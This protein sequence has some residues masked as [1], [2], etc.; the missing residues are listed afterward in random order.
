MKHFGILLTGLFLCLALSARADETRPPNFIVVFVDD[1]GYADIG[2]FGSPDIRTPRLDGLAQ[3]GMRFTH[4]YAQHICG[5]SRTALMTGSHPQRVAEK[6]NIKRIHPVVHS[7]E[8]T[9]AE[10]L[11]TRGYATGC[12]GKWD[13]AG[14]SQT[15]FDPGLM[16][17]HQGFD[18][19]FGTPSSND[20][21]VD[22]YRNDEKIEAKADMG[23]L[24]KRN[25]DEVI[26]FIERNR[27]QPFFAYVPYSMV[28]TKLGAS[29]EFKD[30]SPRGLYGDAVEE[31]DFNCGRI[32]DA[33]KEYDLAKNT[34][35]LFTSDNGPWLIKNKDFEDGKLTTDHG[36]SAGPLRSGKVSTWEGGVRVP[37]ILW[38]P[39]HVPANTECN[40]IAA[41]ID[42]LPTFAKLAGTDAPTDRVL[43]GIDIRHLFEGKFDLA[44]EERTFYYYFINSLQAVRQGKWKL[45]LP[46]PANPKWLGKFANNKHIAKRDWQGFKTAFLIDLET[47]PGET[48]DVAADHPKVVERLLGIAEEAREDIGDHDRV[49]KNVR[50]F[51]PIKDQPVAKLPGGLILDLD[52][53]HGVTTEDGD[54]VSL[55]ENQVEESLA[56]DFIKRDKGRKKPGTGRPTL[57]NALPGLKGHNALSFLQQELVC[58][59]E[60]AFDHLTQGSGCT[61]MT[62]ISVREQRVGLKDVNSF[63]GNLKNGKFYGGLWGCLNDDNTLWWGMRNGLSFGRFDE[64]NPKLTGPKLEVGKFYVVAGRI[65]K[66]TGEVTVELFVDSAEPVAKAQIQVNPDSNP[67]KLAIGQERDA[68]NHPGKESFDGDIARFLIWEKPLSDVELKSTIKQL[69]SK[70]FP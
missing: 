27:D 62:V 32:I 67:S 61:W 47:D 13:M 70:Y 23:S 26:G 14:H 7:E 18:Y 42:L 49:G 3:E 54:R 59:E 30:K 69:H 39:G 4:F 41:T 50:F 10:V 24:T 34:Y 66:G 31:I 65:G 15:K 22:L 48:Q 19:F 16:P 57:R 35:F 6:G 52:A 5:P 2:C 64:N 58:M 43:D 20:N 17:N 38:A 55:W 51:D 56:K 9:I 44:D 45:H 29:A 28:H 25:T 11:K 21:T 33:L 46:R 63:F 60:D 12:F 68:T 1:L 37:T 36:G 53:D 40:E 8:I